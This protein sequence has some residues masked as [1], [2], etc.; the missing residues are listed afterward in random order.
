MSGY[1]PEAHR[2]PLDHRLRMLSVKADRLARD[3]VK[4]GQR[5][6]RE[7]RPISFAISA[8]LYKM[9][10]QTRAGKRRERREAAREALMRSE[11]ALEAA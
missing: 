10:A 9:T 6:K 3:K 5:I 11:R 8:L 4:G 1:Q 2:I 7:L